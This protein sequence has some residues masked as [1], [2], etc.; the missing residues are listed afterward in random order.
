MQNELSWLANVKSDLSSFDSRIS[1]F[2]NELKTCETIALAINVTNSLVILDYPI[3]ILTIILIVSFATKL[4]CIIKKS[5]CRL[6]PFTSI[7]L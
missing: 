1:S 6:I 2:Q 5:N 3:N 4:I 7:I